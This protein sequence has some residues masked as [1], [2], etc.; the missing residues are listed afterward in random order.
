M[1]VICCINWN[2][3]IETFATSTSALVASLSLVVAILA[4]WHAYK[5]YKRALKNKQSEVLAQY[6]ERYSNDDSIRKVIEYITYSNDDKPTVYDKEMFLRFF[7]EL[8]LMIER[9]YLS[10][11]IVGDMFAYYFLVIWHCKEE[12]FFWDKDMQF[13]FKTMEEAK[14]SPDWRLAARLYKN[15]KGKYLSDEIMNFKFKNK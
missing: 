4:V 8:E 6:N 15:L 5:E 14:N 7:E 3:V 1:V 13:P 9:G 12:T 10:I 11:D 2:E